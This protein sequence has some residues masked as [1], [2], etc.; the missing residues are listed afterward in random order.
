MGS[1]AEDL[2]PVAGLH[3]TM[4]RVPVFSVAG[5]FA[6]A[7]AAGAFVY[8]N[9]LADQRAEDRRDDELSACV[10][11][12]ELRAD[13]REVAGT[14]ASG[15]NEFAAILIGEGARTPEQQAR[16]DEARVAFD[17]RVVDP[18]NELADEEGSLAGRD[19]EP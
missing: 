9:R 1:R 14:T 19:C 18:L 6:L 2:D 17:A 10:R 7:V 12:N 5:I 16:I 8:A 13:V 11:G 15:F 3:R 4:R